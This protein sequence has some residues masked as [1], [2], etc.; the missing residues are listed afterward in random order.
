M[1]YSWRFSGLYLKHLTP[2]PQTKLKII[3]SYKCWMLTTILRIISEILKL[4]ED[5]TENE[6]L[7]RN[8]ASPSIKQCSSD[9]LSGLLLLAKLLQLLYELYHWL[10][11][12]HWPSWGGSFPPTKHCCIFFYI[13]ASL[14]LPSG[15]IWPRFIFVPVYYLWPCGD[16]AGAGIPTRVGLCEYYTR[17]V[18]NLF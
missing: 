11:T 8:T 3:K 18:G 6:N 7:R 12:F 13:I 15:F 2:Y 5:K 1:L 17:V 10:V 9:G 16:G 14:N 4:F